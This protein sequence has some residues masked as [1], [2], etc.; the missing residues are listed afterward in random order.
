MGDN[1]KWCITNSSVSY[2]VDIL[3]VGGGPAGVAAA[4]TAARRGN[5]V[6]LLEKQGFLGG[7]A[8]GGL[9]ATICGLYETNEDWVVKN[10]PKQLVFG[11]AQ[12]FREKLLA[13]NGLTPPQLYGNTYVDAHQSFVW[14]YAAEQ[15]LL[16]AGVSILYHT[17]VIE[18]QREG[19]VITQVLA[20]GMSEYMTI[21]AKRWIDTTGDGALVALSGGNYRFG[22]DGVVQ[23]PTLIFKLHGVDTKAFWDYFGENTICHDEFSHRL[24]EAEKKYG[25][26]MPRKKIWVFAC[27]T[28]G[29]I[30]VNATSISKEDGTNFTCS[31]TEDLSQAETLG[32]AQALTYARFFKE[33]IP[34]C[35]KSAIG[36]HGSQVGVRQTRSIE[37][38]TTLKNSDVESCAKFPDG[39]AKSSWPI[40]LHK[41]EAPK[42]VW[43]TNDYYEIPYGTLVPKGYENL[44][45]AGR[46]I[47]AQHE[48]LASSRVTA[49]CFSMGQAAGIA[50]DVSIQDG[51]PF[52]SID[53]RHIRKLLNEDGAQLDE[54]INCGV[55][56]SK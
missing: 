55:P 4:E 37:G 7:Q 10:G 35:E 8:T 42:L 30:Y 38:I 24:R 5:R 20:R 22:V 40:E 11:F 26:P 50:A 2:D 51:V 27:T 19:A 49:Q 36:E 1:H 15:M 45:V 3:V 31:I 25:L 21:R 6:L 53:G 41:G 56:Q 9:S 18:T 48:A 32:R 39:I 34:G 28:D 47:D 12:R 16:A 29:E 52:G 13:E 17:H 44:I 33:Y 14:K 43:L 54:S 23:N 46:C